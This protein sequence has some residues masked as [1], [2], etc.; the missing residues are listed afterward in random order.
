MGIYPA[1]SWGRTLWG[2][3]ALGMG[4][5]EMLETGI[6]RGALGGV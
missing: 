3:P 6:S 4:E 5:T 2:H 1:N